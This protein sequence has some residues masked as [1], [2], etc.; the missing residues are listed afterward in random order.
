MEGGRGMQSPRPY[1]AQHTV[2]SPIVGQIQDGHE[3]SMGHGP[4]LLL[5]V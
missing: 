3:P 5:D 1:F 2:C 4:H